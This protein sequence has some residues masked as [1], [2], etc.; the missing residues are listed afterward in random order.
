M[1]DNTKIIPYHGIYRDINFI[2]NTVTKEEFLQKGIKAGDCI[3]WWKSLNA[4]GYGCIMIN[5]RRMYAH[6]YAYELFKGTIP[7]GMSV[8]HTCDNTACI[9]P[10]HLYLGTQQQNMRDRQVRKRTHSKLTHQ[11]I[12]EIRSLRK[13]L[14]GKV[15]GKIY[16]VSAEYV[17][18]IWGGQYWK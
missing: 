10:D 14:P 16:G 15:V 8:L 12:T 18:D 4:G 5:Y 6:R 9:N 11:Q 2:E 1:F 3:L 7:E 13:I 17:Y